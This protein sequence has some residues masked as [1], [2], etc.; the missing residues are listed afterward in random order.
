MII[1]DKSMEVG[2]K[3]IDDQH[4]E[5]VAKL[6]A[7]VQ[8]GAKSSTKEVTEA[9][10][11]SLGAYIKRHFSDEQKLHAESGFPEA[12]WHI[13][14]HKYYIGEFEALRKEYLLNGVSASFSLKLTNSLVQWF[15]KHIKTADVRFGKFVAGG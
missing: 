2:V 1:F 11:D 3:L 15:V 5:L 14:Q 8:G 4:R 7:F 6:N 12:A 13:E 9:M 10:L